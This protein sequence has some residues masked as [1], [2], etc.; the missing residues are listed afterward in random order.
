MMTSYPAIDHELFERGLRHFAGTCEGDIYNISGFCAKE[1]GV[2]DVLINS[3]EGHSW[4]MNQIGDLL[5]NSLVYALPIEYRDEWLVCQT[6]MTFL[7]LPSGAFGCWRFDPAGDTIPFVTAEFDPLT[8]P[9]HLRNAFLT[10]EG[11]V[12]DGP[13]CLEPVRLPSFEFRAGESYPIDDPTFWGDVFL[14]NEMQSEVDN[15]RRHHG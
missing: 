4:F 11:A 3:E 12:F 14:L 8:I 6:D 10:A 5:E 9:F 13:L 15:A 7:L 2:P 1:L